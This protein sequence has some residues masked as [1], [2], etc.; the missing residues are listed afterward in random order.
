[1]CAICAYSLFL[2]GMSFLKPERFFVFPFRALRPL[3]M[4]TKRGE[5]MA[6]DF[7]KSF[8]ASKA[9]KKVR[10]AYLSDHPYCERCLKLGL[11]VPAEHVHHKLYID[12]PEKV[13]DPMLALNYDNLEALCE[14][15]H[16]KEH[17]AQAQVSDDTYF[18]EDGNLVHA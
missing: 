5:S 17:N 14:P 4:L 16:S 15:C 9:W 8:Y 12:T 3:L 18:D 13:K 6:R 11:I 10:S 7:A 2:V 1:M